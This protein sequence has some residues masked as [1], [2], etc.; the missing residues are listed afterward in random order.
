M[1]PALFKGIHNKQKNLPH[2]PKKSD[3]WS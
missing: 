1:S 2:N 3:T